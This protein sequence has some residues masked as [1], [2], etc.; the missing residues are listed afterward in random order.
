[1][2]VAGQLLIQI[3]AETK[4]LR[5][6][7]DKAGREVK[8]FAEG[9]R[10]Q[11]SGIRSQFRTFQQVMAGAGAAQALAMLERS[12]DAVASRAKEL[13]EQAKAAGM[14]VTEMTGGQWTDETVAALTEM[15]NDL[16]EVKEAV[17]AVAAE[18]AA[19]LGPIVK[20]I[21]QN[22]KEI[23]A[24]LPKAKIPTTVEEAQDQASR[25]AKTGVNASRTGEWFTNPTGA[26]MRWAMESAFGGGGESRAE[27][28]D[29]A[30][31]AAEEKKAAEDR[32]KNRQKLM[33]KRDQKAAQQALDEMKAEERAAEERKKRAAELDA[34]QQEQEKKAAQAELDAM[35]Q[36]QEEEKKRQEEKKKR[37]EEAD[38]WQQ[39][40]EKK[41]A[42]FELD[43]M[44]EEA[45]LLQQAEEKRASIIESREGIGA[46]E[47]GTQAAFSAMNRANKD[48]IPSQQL[49]ELKGIRRDLRSRDDSE[50]QVVNDL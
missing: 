50:E 3:A 39:E 33:E 13:G 30:K 16:D 48:K 18:F 20:E 12:F 45:K 2:A 35:K 23:I 46:I 31:K 6:G 15:K 11:I 42:Q 41:L 36:E 37:L 1:M 22:I 44:K 9:I 32:E 34:W 21:S 4:E 43:Q 14:S 38:R 29:A 24:D 27:E 10:S 25:A 40:E 8:G 5:A 19:T 47:K 26:A 49:A 28:Q 7:L 17:T